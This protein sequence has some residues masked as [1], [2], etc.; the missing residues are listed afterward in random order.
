MN[1]L[2]HLFALLIALFI[3]GCEVSS[4]EVNVPPL[5]G[6]EAEVITWV[7]GRQWFPATI[8]L[9]VREEDPG[10]IYLEANSSA[11]K[12][13]K[14]VIRLNIIDND[15]DWLPLDTLNLLNT[16]LPT[17]VTVQYEQF[18]ARDNLTS[19]VWLGDS[20]DRGGL[21]ITSIE[22]EDG[23]VF[24]CSRCNGSVSSSSLSSS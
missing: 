6:R 7:S 17:A 1:R 24:S 15:R 10:Y 2:N 20:N 16:E 8:G 23:V 5:E 19:S 11:N 4:P 12:G 22:E 21:R 3:T 14:R 9:L 13:Y 18:R